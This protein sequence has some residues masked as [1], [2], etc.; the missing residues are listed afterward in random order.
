VKRLLLALTILSVAA[1]GDDGATMDAGAGDGG[2]AASL[3]PP[4]IP[5][6]AEGAPPAVLTEC[7]SGWREVTGPH[8]IECDPYPESGAATCGSGEAHFPGEAACRPIGDPCPAGDFADGIVDDGTV[9][10]V[11]AGAAS[12]DGSRATPF[13]ALSE[14]RWTSLAAGTTVALARGMY[15]GTLPLRAATRVVGACAGETLVVGPAAPIASLVSVTTSGEPAVVR[16]LTITDSL[17]FGAVAEGGRR[18][19][20]EG[21]IV[22]RANEVAVMASGTGAEITMTSVVIRDTRT[23]DRFGR[24]IV[25]QEAGRIEASFVLVEGNRDTGVFASD[26]GS[27]IVISDSVVRDTLP[28]RDDDTGGRGIGVQTAARLEATRVLVEGN[29][30]AGMY[31]SESECALMDVIVRGTRAQERG[32]TGG[33]GLELRFGAHAEISRLLVAENEDVG[34][35]ISDPDTSA[36]LDGVVMRNAEAAPSGGS[37]GGGLVVAEEADVEA[38]RLLVADNGGTGVYVSGGATLTLTDTAVRGTES[39]TVG[40]R[41]VNVQHGARLTASR[42]LVTDSREAAMFIGD[43]DVV[44]RDALLRDTRA[45]ASDGVFGR[46]L[47]VQGSSTLDAERIRVE[48]SREFGIVATGG[49][50]ATMRDASIVGTERASCAATTCAA[51]PYGYGAAAVAG[52]LDLL[53]FEVRDAATCGVF[54]AGDSAMPGPTDVD[55]AE[56]VVAESE[57]GAYVQIEGYDLMRLTNGVEYRDNGANLDSTML[58]VPGVI[59]DLDDVFP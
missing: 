1:C 37:G 16:N 9:V 51:R 56:G 44:L 33:H 5:W 55:L 27:E 45:R 7:P 47:N 34:I 20:L 43:A 53:R 42:L 23:A 50:S 38:T 3:T 41:G 46:G 2:D 6:L 8:T 58:P 4:D 32:G 17:G 54:L 22:E 28:Q 13:G 14:V 29:R 59:D 10:Y 24:G 21:V 48:A 18:L 39:E 11:R 19:S 57:I 52:A 15:E 36:R 25:A 49:A 12:G 35:F 30:E 31:I 40:G 26:S